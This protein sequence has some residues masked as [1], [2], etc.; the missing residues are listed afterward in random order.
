MDTLIRQIQLFAAEFDTV[1]GTQFMGLG[2]GELTVAGLVFIGFLLLR[3]VFTR[4]VLAQVRLFTGRTKTTLDDHLAEAM[5]GPIRFV[6]VVFGLF[7]AMQVVHFDPDIEQYAERMIRSLIAFGIFWTAYR[8]VEPLSVFFD[9]LT[10]VSRHPLSRD[11]KSF[12][13]KSIKLLVF[14][15]GAVAVLQEWGF[16]VTGFVASLGLAGM[17]VALAA[18]DSL[19]NL[20]GSLTIFMDR[21]YQRGD[22]IETPAVEGTVEEIGLR[23]TKVRTF[24]KALVTVP[25]APLANEPLINWSRMTNRRIK[26]TIGVEYRTRP[27]QIERI[28]GRIRDFLANDPE[29]QTDG[30]T[31][32]VN[33]YEFGPSSIDIFLYFFTRTTNWGQ[34]M[35]V[36]E[37]CLL[38][39]MRIV[40]EEGAAFAFPSQSVYLENLPNAA[41]GGLGDGSIAKLG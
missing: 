19:A 12:F 40:E 9:R 3:Q 39:F 35:A 10:G 20:F 22:W 8:L 36:R 6:F 37:R 34:Y 23:S 18:K 16:N 1:F 7:T 41:A 26:M 38:T 2:L 32:L 15:V 13:V 29:I 31:T 28:L 33:L 17:A 11:L 24:A 4:L 27:E 30:V 5:E 14:L 25:N 21:T